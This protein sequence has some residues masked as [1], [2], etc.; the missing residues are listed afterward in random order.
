M[1]VH[2]KRILKDTIRTRDEVMVHSLQFLVQALEAGIIT[3]RF[4]AVYNVSLTALRI[5]QVSIA[6]YL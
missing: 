3:T 5:F 1:V 6:S 4:Y 2:A